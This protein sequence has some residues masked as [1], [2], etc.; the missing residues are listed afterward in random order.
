MKKVFFILFAASLMFF[1]TPATAQSNA[2]ATTQSVVKGDINEDGRVDI[3]DINAVIEIMAENGTIE[4]K[5]YYWYA[6][7]TEPTVDNYTTLATQVTNYPS[8][9]EYTTTT[10][11]YVYFLIANNKSITKVMNGAFTANVSE[12]TSP[13]D[14]Y[15][16]YK[17]NAGIASGITLTIY[18][19]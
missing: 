7:Q 15:K 16:L 8:T 12:T 10:R 3:G 13:I 1:V 19:E 5:K 18:I 17:S 14:G 9:I 11:N 4:T 2:D 6:G